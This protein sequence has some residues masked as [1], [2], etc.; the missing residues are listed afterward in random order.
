MTGGQPQQPS[1]PR[2]VTVSGPRRDRARGWSARAG[3]E[4]LHAQ[5][6]LGQVY[7]RSLVRD[8][9]RLSLGVLAVLVVVLGGLPAVFALAPGLRTAEVFGIRLAWL[10]LGAAAYPVL[11]GAALFHIRYAERV[12]RD[13]TE[14]LGPSPESAP[15]APPGPSPDLP[16][17]DGLVAQFLPQPGGWEVPP[18]PLMGRPDRQGHPTRG[19]RNCATSPVVG[20]GPPTAPAGQDSGPPGEV[21]VERHLRGARNCATSPVAGDDPPTA[22]AGQDSGPPGDSPGTRPPGGSPDAMQPPGCGNPETG[23]G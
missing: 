2:R 19:A 16:P 21:P 3:A 11:L 13:F 10:L 6:Q 18:A 22:P 5:P 7:V 12:E 23:A 9:L 4:D 8:Q 1:P 17:G 15:P 20:E 14:L